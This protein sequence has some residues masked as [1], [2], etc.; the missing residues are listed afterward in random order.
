MRNSYGRGLAL[1]PLALLLVARFVPAAGQPAQ[2]P[3][4][5]PAPVQVSWK[6]EDWN[7]QPM[8]DDVNLPMPC[9]GAM[10]FRKVLTGPPRA[11]NESNLLEDREVVVGSVDD[12]AP[13]VGYL[14]SDF[15]AGG[16]FEPNGQR[17][18]LIGKYE[19]TTQQYA[20]LTGDPACR[21]VD[22]DKA[23]L[24]V[25]NV[26]WFDAVEFT[27]HY[28][29]WLYASQSNA[30]PRTADRPGFVRLPTELEWEFAARGGLA[31]SDAERSDQTFV[32][33][34]E[35]LADYAWF[36]GP[37]SSGNELKLVGS[38]KPNPLGL[39]DML[40]NGEE[41]VL[42]PFRL[43]RAGRLHGQSGG[44]VARGGSYLTSRE[45]VRS[46]ARTEY[47]LFS[48]EDKDE[49]RLPSLG[50]RVAIGATALN[51]ARQV[52]ALKLEWEAARR[53]ESAGGNKTPMQLLEDLVGKANP[54][55]R[56]T[57][58]AALQ[59][60]TGESRRRNELQDRAMKSLLSSA[61]A[62]RKNL[63]WTAEYLEQLNKIVVIDGKGT[64][65][66]ADIARQ[67][68]A[69]FDA[70]KVN[71]EGYASVYAD[72]IQ[73][74]GTD[75]QPEAVASQA[76]VLKSDL[77]QRGRGMDLPTVDAVVSDAGRY[78][79]GTARNTSVILESVVGRRNWTIP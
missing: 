58:R 22:P 20:A 55:Q 69:R 75:F 53:L 47:P 33:S 71:F 15:V 62:I 35:N 4:S 41:I 59:Q 16:F 9:G 50:F 23:A 44:F 57:L 60:L 74:L 5:A 27:R 30:L 3:A 32:P 68:R 12:P 26:S 54:E 6:Q 48:P 29:K 25:V 78:R 37:E 43:N 11:G 14:H 64:G 21:T 31:V 10:A 72:L 61:I 38:I 19:V 39:F 66:Q 77:T 7:P 70:Q 17:Y 34:T 73:Q 1:A 49:L 52:S 18:F 45:A 65:V 79:A 56:A 13:Y 42:D 8:A 76:S 46:S 67:A 63:L 28:N 24:P 40:G 2:P 51:D 36:A